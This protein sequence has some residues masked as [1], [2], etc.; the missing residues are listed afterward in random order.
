MRRAERRADAGKGRAG[1]VELAAVGVVDG[2]LPVAGG[3]FERGQ[4]RGI[5]RAFAEP[6]DG[7]QG[8]QGLAG[9]EHGPDLGQGQADE[10]VAEAG[11]TRHR[12][13]PRRR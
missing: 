6:G 4:G 5:G 10:Y 12:P 13:G 3:F 9:F 1:L 11:D 2:R 7:F 8:L